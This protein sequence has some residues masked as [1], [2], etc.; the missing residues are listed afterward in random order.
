MFGAAPAEKTPTS[1]DELP[2]V[3]VGVGANHDTATPHDETPTVM[4]G[5][6]GG[7]NT[8][9]N[10]TPT[11]MLGATAAG[12][13]PSSPSLSLQIDVADDGEA[14]AGSKR[15][16]LRIGHFEV[17]HELGEGGMGVV[18]AAYDQ[19]LDRNVAIKL[20]H[21]RGSRVD[22]AHERM[23][24]EARAMARL[25]HPNV[26]QVHEVG[27]FRGQTF[28]AMEYVE[29]LT[30]RQ[31]LDATPRS[32][33]EVLE[34]LRQAGLGLAAAHQAGII[35]RDFKPDN[36][37]VGADQ[38]VK[39]L[40]FGLARWNE[41]E[42]LP[43][44]APERVAASG[45]D[46][47]D[48]AN[49]TKTGF[50]MGTPAYMSPEQYKGKPADARSDQFSFSVALYEALYGR[51]PFIGKTAAQLSRAITTQAPLPP[52]DDTE[53]PEW[54]HRMVT[55][56]L[57]RAPGERF[58]SMDVLL[59][60]FD[61]FKAKL[62]THN[63]EVLRLESGLGALFVLAFWVLDWMFLPEHIMLALGIRLVI[64]GVAFV[65]H[66]LCRLRPQLVERHV[67]ALALFANLVAGWGMSAIVWLE[68]GLESPYYAG[69]NLLIL[70]IGIMFLWSPRRT[71]A[72]SGL[73]YGFYMSPL[74][75]GLLEVHD[76]PTVLSN[77]CFLLSTIVIMA[78]AQR[79]RYAQKHREF[80]AEQE[81]NQLREEVA[82]MAKS[83]GKRSGA[84]G[85]LRRSRSRSLTR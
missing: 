25:S 16:I 26:V 19:H 28:V 81:R 31:W 77:Q 4:F 52:P 39:V 79:Q 78:L 15:G 27:E 72:F 64:G 23:I 58:P 59:A 75:L 33:R 70:S 11:V 69:L 12:T 1:H 48:E 76:L 61:D 56:G 63:A 73:V 32:W 7:A 44:L 85:S 42:E 40:D 14:A 43:A 29:G 35:H 51:R 71:L 54:V 47:A 68:G 30:L 21:A 22:T 74:A 62:D 84:S 17:L 60:G 37:I 24:R 9:H 49:L 83:A 36:V 66:L 38:Q 45:L 6:A 50:M 3:M 41:D 53:V 8:S 2:T 20:L 13:L 65:V 67:D 82:A 57:A 34:I 10:E 18:Y 46:S 55:R 80:L 5:T